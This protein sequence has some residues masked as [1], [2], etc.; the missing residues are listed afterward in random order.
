L[1]YFSVRI[2][3]AAHQG[4]HKDDER[5]FCEKLPENADEKQLNDSS[6]EAVT[7]KKAS[8]Q[9]VA[10]KRRAEGVKSGGIQL[11]EAYLLKLL[12]WV[13]LSELHLIMNG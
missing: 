13:F 1:L 6:V 5:Q 8:G 3:L 4:H 9:I 11:L 2:S 7:M 10:F 12:S